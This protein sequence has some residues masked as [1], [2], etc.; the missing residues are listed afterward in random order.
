MPTRVAYGCCHRRVNL[1][2]IDGLSKS[3]AQSRYLHQIA[4][5]WL[6]RLPN[7]GNRSR[8][9]SRRSAPDVHRTDGAR[10]SSSPADVV[11][12]RPS[13]VVPIVG[14]RNL[15]CARLARSTWPP[16][17]MPGA[18]LATVSRCAP[19]EAGPCDAAR[20]EQPCAGRVWLSND[21]RR[22]TP[23]ELMQRRPQSGADPAHSGLYP[24]AVK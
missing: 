13:C 10:E 19:A 16:A 21:E 8:R 5:T 4:G 22:P 7:A 15:G 17:G 11:D 12:A 24:D 3:A 18:A 6:P 20:A 9:G 14:L 1:P 2:G 23:L